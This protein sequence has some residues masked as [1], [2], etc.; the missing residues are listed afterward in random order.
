MPQ[1]NKYELYTEC[2][3]GTLFTTPRQNKSIKA[4]RIRPSVAH[5]GFSKCEKPNPFVRLHLLVHDFRYRG[6]SSAR[7]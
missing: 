5:Q 7:R 3:T 6:L 4:Y 1:K 2:I